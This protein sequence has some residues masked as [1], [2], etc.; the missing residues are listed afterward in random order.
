M[1]TTSKLQAGDIVRF[2]NVV[3]GYRFA[4]VVKKEKAVKPRSY[5]VTLAYPHG[6][7]ATEVFAS[8]TTWVKVNS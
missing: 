5:F 6:G 8:N 3:V 7:Q 2:G 1:I 4:T